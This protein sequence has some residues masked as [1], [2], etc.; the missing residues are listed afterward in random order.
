MP[1]GGNISIK[2]DNQ[3]LTGSG[4]L[5][6]G[7]YVCLSIKDQGIGIPR[8]ILANIFDPFFTTKSKGH[9]LGLATCH[10]IITR[11]GGDIRAQSEPGQGTEFKILLPAAQGKAEGDDHVPALAQAGG[12]RVLIMDDVPVIRSVVK[13]MLEKSGYLVTCTENGT[14]AV[15]AFQQAWEMRDPFVAVIFDLTIPGGM[16][17]SEAVS[18]IR[19]I[20]KNVPVIVSSG[21]AQDPIMAHPTEFGF[22]TSISKP[23]TKNAILE[24]LAK[25]IK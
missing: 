13:K 23:F 4:H 2:A 3:E 7:Q 25:H 12:G 8:N 20:D 5:P 19:K 22:T 6:G 17:G 11:H 24:L 14:E 10:S 16:G 9:G 18:H 15:K 1:R 21:Y